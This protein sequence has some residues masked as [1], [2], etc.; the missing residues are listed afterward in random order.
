L[1]AWP[2]ALDS[3]NVWCLHVDSGQSQILIRRRTT[4][5][6]SIVASVQPPCNA[7]QIATESKSQ[8]F[9]LARVANLTQGSPIGWKEADKKN[10]L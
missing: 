7:L 1:E 9:M 2:Q 6:L 3:K 4:K 5:R 8:I 10:S